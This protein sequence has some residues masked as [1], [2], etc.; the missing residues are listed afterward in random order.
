MVDARLK[1]PPQAKF[2]RGSLALGLIGVC[3]LANALVL[4]IG[5]DDL[6]EGY[7][8]QQATRVLNGQ[9][10]F[11]D[12]E[13]FYT[14]GL[15]YLHAALFAVSGG[16]S[17]VAPRAV[18][19]VARAAVAVLLYVLAR[20]LMHRPLWAAAPAVF[21]LV[22]LDHTP[23]RWEPHPGWPATVFALL[24]VWA[25]THAPSTPWLLASGVSAAAAYAFKQNTGV[26]ILAAVLVWG[27]LAPC[28]RLVRLTVPLAAFVC[29]TAIWLAPLV[30]ALHGNVRLLGAVVGAIN[31]E[32]LFSP[33]EASIVV[34]LAALA[35]G[36]RLIRRERDPRLGCYLLAGAALF[37]TQ[38]PRMDTLHL[39]WSA[40]L[41]LVIGTAVLDRLRPALAAAAILGLAV[42]AAPTLLSRVEY[43]ALAGQS[44]GGVEA[45]ATTA[46]EISG[47]VADVEHRTAPGE[48]IFVYPTSPLLYVLAQR[49]NATRFDHLNPGAAN[50]AQIEQVIVDLEAAH[51]Q[52]VVISEYWRG[53][54]GDPGPNTPLERWI[55]TRFAEVARHGTYRVLLARL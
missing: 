41:L 21:L 50:A 28:Q 15:A 46:A 47:V 4:R 38:Y 52:L 32:G 3:L 54:Q 10:P 49:P 43:L 34:P 16:P 13:T 35:G 20:P 19:L 53:V 2:T 51:V 40:P 14:P 26:F 30:V 37:G 1:R 8:V 6:D 24:T 36:V 29:V 31:Q 7:F 9:V 17:L 11:G 55:D 44:I 33:P 48:P 23:V 25:M 5:I 18:G 22:G 27:A 42:L 45:P 39:A 12:F